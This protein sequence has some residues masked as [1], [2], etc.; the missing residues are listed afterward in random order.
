MT[1]MIKAKAVVADL[2]QKRRDLI[3]HGT[4]LSDER[5]SVALAAYTGDQ[6]APARL[7]AINT[8]LAT[9]ASELASLDAALKAAAEHVAAAQQVEAR[10]ADKER[11]KRVYTLLIDLEKLGP[12]L[13]EGT[14]RFG[15]RR[16]AMPTAEV[17]QFRFRADPPLRV[18]A[19][20]LLSSLFQELGAIGLATTKWPPMRADVG[21]RQD[22]L[23]ALVKAMHAEWPFE[24]QRLTHAERSCFTGL[25]G[26]LAKIIRGRLG[27]QMT[28]AA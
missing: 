28:E 17:D 2:E 13:D 27:K 1:D 3:R 6:K 26:A 24:L 14:G 22:L 16:S 5:C 12:Q 7:D 4:D 9:H 21:A 15:P 10:A 25:L 23:H 8:A 11:I 19:A 18:K 20:A